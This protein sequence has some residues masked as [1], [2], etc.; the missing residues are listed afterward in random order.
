V[1]GTRCKVQGTRCKVL[2]TRCKVQV[3]VQGY[4]VQQVQ[5]QGARCRVQEGAKT[6]V[7]ITVDGT[8]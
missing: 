8:H 7:L 3:Q 5:V 1:Q 6:V 2:G 4:K